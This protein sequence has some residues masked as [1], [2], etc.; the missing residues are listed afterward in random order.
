MATYT[1]TFFVLATFLPH[2]NT[3]YIPPGPAYPCPKETDNA[4]LFPCVCEKG[5]DAG[6]YV[7][8][9]NT[10]LA[11]M[12]VGLGNIAGMGLPIERLL[13]EE[14]K[15]SNLFGP[16]LH[17]STVRTL[18]IVDT[19]IKSIDEYAFFGVNRTLEEI[20]MYNTR[21]DEFPKKAFKIL[22]NL[23]TLSIDGHRMT[24]LSKDIFAGSLATGRLERL[25]LANGRLSDIPVEAFQNLKKLKK[26]DLHGNRLA[27]L[28]RNQF[29]GLRDTEVLDLSYNNI[30]KLDGSHI[31]D[32]TKLGWCNASHN[33]LPDI[34]RGM[35]ARNTVIK[36]VHL[37]NNK[38]KKLDTNSF[39]GMRFLRRL[40]LQDNEISEV[41]TGT[42]TAVTRIGTVD[43]ARNKITK[44]S[45]QMFQAVKYAELINLAENNITFI[46]KQ[47]F[48]DL[49]LAVVN[50]SH[51]ELSNI[52]PGAFQNC[53]NMTLLDLSHNKLKEINNKAFDENTYASEFQVSYN[54]FTDLG[55]IPIQNMTG[56]KVLNASY[57][58]ITTI[59]KTAFPKLY[60]LHT[61]DISHN[62]LSEIFNAVFQNLFS[63]RFLN[64]SYNSLERIK[65]STFG[66]IPT[67]LE[68]DLSHN[69]LVDV[70]RGSLAKLASCRLLDVS[71]NSLD[72]IFQISISLGEL[73]FAHNNLSEIKISTW[74]SMNALLR[75]NLSHN[76]L[77]DRLTHD[78]F[79]SLLTLQS[80]DLS[81][82]GLTKP[83]WE[84]LNT[85]TS[86]QY[87]YLQHNNLT[88]L[89]K[90]A[91]GNLPTTF[92]LDLSYNQLVD[93]GQ[94]TF[95]GMQQ[96][97]DLSLRGNRLAH[98]QNEVFK[99]L[100]ALRRLDLSYNSLDKIDNKT[101]GLLDDCLS[102]EM[103]N[104]SHNHFGFLSRKMFPANPWI[105]YR[106]M[107][108]DLSY[109]E[110]PV[111]TFDITFGA[112]KLKK[113]DLSNNYI[114][115]IRNNVLGNL[116][117]LEVLDLS[118]NQ[119]KD[120]VS[121][122]SDTKFN[123]P[124]NITEIYLQN[125]TLE[126]LPVE[127]LTNASHLKV[128]DLRNNLL[129]SFY[130]QLVKKIREKNLMVYFE[131]N[132]LKC[133][134]FTRPL[135]HYLHKIPQSIL[136]NDEKYKNLVCF[137]PPSLED[138]NFLELNEDR[139]L[140]ASNV[141]LNDKIR[142]YGNTE[143]DFTSEPD[144]L[145]RDIQFSQTAIYAFW[146]VS[147]TDDVADFYIYVRDSSNN[148]LF[149]Q[150]IAY[151]LRSLTIN[152]DKDFRNGLKNN[153]NGDIEICIQAKSS[154]NFARKWFDSQ[155]QAVQ[156]NFESWPKKLTVDKRRLSK[157]KVRYSWFSN[158][159]LGLVSDS[160]L[161]TLCIFIGVCF[162]R[163]AD[164]EV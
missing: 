84:A 94:R 106:L 83:P 27:T 140:C 54:E 6:L 47:A 102:L 17:R 11:V 35:F 131:N 30:T 141:E 164:L 112:K 154:N 15:I 81:S 8:C 88:S 156:S 9:S 118:N 95:D 36:V 40:Y 68:L 55:Q 13:I 14:C 151:N 67:V 117:S 125:N 91:F 64:L 10:G 110:I 50:I 48:T 76:M 16:L 100:V 108:V 21:I 85:L 143:F 59:P 149:S 71:F 155:C 93:L 38:I 25:H 51:N 26:L 2:L 80:L 77:E 139:L 7:R 148:L 41:G 129:T 12:S 121:R 20:Y 113:L 138:E 92:K 127:T 114:N 74:P 24:S 158:S 3:E 57:N 96:L 126:K 46:D 60:E 72:R 115:D 123:L 69:R 82:N 136:K 116:T 78:A 128:L 122:T 18:H 89:S 147:T 45:Y 31:G 132:K 153:Q 104:L 119:L 37:D 105:P 103:V 133:D 97:L 75:L 73:N 23:T 5:T 161:I 137:E 130:P 34:P 157:K 142:A 39:K 101:N 99:G 65:P 120:L 49:Y 56:I 43:L 52:E 63:L 146:Y 135:K 4:L 32:L 152:I 86:L 145:F 144:V 134:C 109:N 160:I 28:K 29:R 66:T 79:S 19:P 107:E 42:F 44:V 62:N 22:G 124:E 58:S 98:I 33:L 163:L 150:D 159:V 53:N 1:L 111:V 70:S 87:L 61:V 162:R 90:S